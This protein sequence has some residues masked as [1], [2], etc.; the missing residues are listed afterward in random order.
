MPNSQETFIL[1]SAK[2]KK[3]KEKLVI[4]LIKK[5]NWRIPGSE[6]GVKSLDDEAANEILKGE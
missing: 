5:N 6:D 3:E 2:P 4:P 1:Y